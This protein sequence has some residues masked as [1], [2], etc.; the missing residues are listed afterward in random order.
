MDPIPEVRAT[1]AKA[2][3]SLVAA[4]TKPDSH[5]PLD[6][7]D[8]DELKTLTP[9][10]LKMLE[11]N[12]SP[13]ER[14]GAA[15]GLAELSSALGDRFLES[16]FSKVIPFQSS[17][18]MESREGLM[19]FLSFLPVVLKEQYTR[20]VELTFPMIMK[21]M[22]DD[23]DN[24][25]EIAYKAGYGM[26]NLS[27]SSTVSFKSATM[28]NHTM[29]VLPMLLEGCT[30]SVHHRIRESSVQLLG[31]MLH[32]IGGRSP[33]DNR[34]DY[35]A[36][37]G[38]LY[39]GSAR[40]Y[41]AI[42]SH[43]DDATLADTVFATLYIARHDVVA[44]VRQSSFNIWKTV[45]NNSPKTLVEIMPVLV[46]EII[47][48]L[49]T[50]DEEPEE[51]EDEEESIHESD[52]EDS[53]DYD[54][55]SED[56]VPVFSNSSNDMRMAASRALGE[57]VGK[58]GEKVLPV[59]IPKL[60]AALA[61]ENRSSGDVKSRQGL[62]LGLAE[63][64]SVSTSKLLEE[65]MESLLVPA[66]L[67]ALLCDIP[68][69]ANSTEDPAKGVRK[70]ASI[71]FSNMLK[72]MQSS[73]KGAGGAAK[74]VDPSARHSRVLDIV[75]PAILSHVTIGAKATEQDRQTQ[76]AIMGMKEI[77]G[78]RPKEMMEYLLPKL[79]RI[80]NLNC[81]L[82]SSS[83]VDG[84]PSMTPVNCVCLYA[85]A[86][87]SITQLPHYYSMVIPFLVRELICASAMPDESMREQ[88][89]AYLQFAALG[90]ME[91]AASSTTGLNYAVAELGKEIE[92]V[93]SGK[94]KLVSEMEM[95]RM[96]GVW[97]S[98][99]LI[100]CF[101]KD[102]FAS[103]IYSLAEQCPVLLKHLLSRVVETNTDL[104]QK[105][106]E[107]FQTLTK[108]VPLDILIQHVGLIR[109]FF[110]S[111]ASDAKHRAGALEG[112]LNLMVKDGKNIAQEVFAGEKEIAVELPLFVAIKQSVE[113]FVSIYLHG[114]LYNSNSGMGSAMINV[115]QLKETC[116]G[117]IG[118]LVRLSS[119]NIFKPFFIK[120]TGPLIRLLSE[121]RGPTN[122][123]TRV[124][125]LQVNSEYS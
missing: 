93:S 95:H 122:T 3:G 123:S 44:A 105:L 42:R 1:S 92:Y 12:V 68:V 9:W 89:L 114:L 53:M 119:V 65:Y 76:L 85:L 96:W 67:D 20:Y 26:V 58:Q 43:I 78:I 18:K 22:A 62:C 100:T 21:G 27:L 86:S 84:T 110:T 55:E 108:T 97:M 73:D 63:I 102:P 33:A 112:I 25:R 59:I 90:V 125:I 8:I 50:G 49:S 47:S 17:T 57:L 45:V 74:T 118:E 15:Q 5:A 98:S 109:G 6:E 4:T 83:A 120:T 31:E 87:A 64:V 51:V 111:L 40:M 81:G 91:N 70:T 99:Q 7:S 24:V 113:P 39:S 46:Q 28:H 79:L 48:K 69:A 37:D 115:T 14:S 23:F 71:A 34:D 32:R 38:G 41:N 16:I 77:I 104:L 61:K 80:A 30:S 116:A 13:V 124:S 52:D 117:A 2:L 60:R 54:D 35:T 107:C 106:H 66:L 29:L 10:L 56:D 121:L 72:T 19:W 82:S 94:S 88:L 36:E 11:C 101:G 103:R 75:V